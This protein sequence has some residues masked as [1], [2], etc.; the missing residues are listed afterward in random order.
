MNKKNPD[1]GNAVGAKFVSKSQLIKIMTAC[2]P[3]RLRSPATPLL[4]DY[5][6][7]TANIRQI[8]ETS[9]FRR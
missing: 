7:G 2:M 8:F 5:P 4:T 3:D 6:N 9:K 1:R